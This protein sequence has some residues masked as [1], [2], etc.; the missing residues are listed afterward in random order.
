M[1]KAMLAV[2]SNG[3]CPGGGGCSVKNMWEAPIE[4]FQGCEDQRNDN[5]RPD[6]RTGAATDE[7][8]RNRQSFN[9][10]SDMP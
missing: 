4:C 9:L 6:W 7:V 2:V 8:A 3:F 1:E 5:P 10:F